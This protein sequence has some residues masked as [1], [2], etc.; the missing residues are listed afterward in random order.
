MR[1]NACMHACMYDSTNSCM[2]VCIV[3]VVGAAREPTACRRSGV[4]KTA[5]TSVHHA[6]D[7]QDR[8]RRLLDGW[9]EV[10]HDSR[11]G[12]PCATAADPTSIPIATT[13]RRIVAMI[14][15]INPRLNPRVV[16]RRNCAVTKTEK[17]F[18]IFPPPRREKN[19]KQTIRHSKLHTNILVSFYNPSS[20][21]LLSA[22]ASL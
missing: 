17:T 22:I 12:V 9:G 8:E 10:S 15:W 5:L 19:T 14:P 2:H 7:R 18:G 1:S 11:V 20:T 21:I 16:M 4:L 3:E 6:C 13:A